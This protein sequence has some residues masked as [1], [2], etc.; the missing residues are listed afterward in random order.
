MKFK[1]IVTIA[2]WII[3]LLSIGF[4]KQYPRVDTLWFGL[5][6]LLV[7][8]TAINF[9]ANLISHGWDK[10][11]FSVSHHGW[12][13]WFIRFPCDEYEETKKP[14]ICAESSNSPGDK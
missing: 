5:S 6:F 1:W 3:L 10:R 4:S 11:V 14:K 8:G 13:R 7:V 12:P 2:F 9:L